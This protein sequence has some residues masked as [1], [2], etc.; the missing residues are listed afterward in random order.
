LDDQTIL[1]YKAQPLHQVLKP[2]LVS[3]DYRIFVSN[4]CK[5][6]KHLLLVARDLSGA[7]MAYEYDPHIIRTEVFFDDH[8]GIQLSFFQSPVDDSSHVGGNGK[9]YTATARV[10]KVK[11]EHYLGYLST[12]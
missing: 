11:P 5:S 12:T 2:Y 4:S 9:D 8:T 6:C 1:H 3:L 7:N 10:H